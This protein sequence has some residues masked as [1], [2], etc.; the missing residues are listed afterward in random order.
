MLFDGTKTEVEE[1][2]N[3]PLGRFDESDNTIEAFQ[4]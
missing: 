4:A 1:E 3:L 2:E